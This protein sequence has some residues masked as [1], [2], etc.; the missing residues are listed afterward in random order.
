MIH[1][2]HAAEGVDGGIRPRIRR[3]SGHRYS[4]SSL[5]TPSQLLS[6]HTAEMISAAL[7]KR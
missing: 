2:T 6:H 5:A 7:T 4:G 3:S 1:G